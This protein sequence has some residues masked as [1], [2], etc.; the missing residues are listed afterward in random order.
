[1]KKMPIAQIYEAYKEK[2]EKKHRINFSENFEMFREK[3]KGVCK[4]DDIDKYKLV[5]KNLGREIEDQEDYELMLKDLAKEKLI[6]I[7]II[8]K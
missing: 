3:V 4:L 1:M 6:S 5:E 2:E 7:D 8:I